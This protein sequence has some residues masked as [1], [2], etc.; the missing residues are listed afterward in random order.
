MAM[1]TAKSA[2]APPFI[3][4]MV[5]AAETRLCA[6]I[7]HCSNL[8]FVSFSDI[9]NTPFVRTDG[10]EPPAWRAYEG[11]LPSDLLVCAKLAAL[12]IRAA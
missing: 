4:V 2:G 11:S 9:E 8:S 10:F 1:E 12:L 7:A 5:A 6:I 3:W